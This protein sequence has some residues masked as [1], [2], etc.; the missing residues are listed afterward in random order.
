M[1]KSRSLA[2][3]FVLQF[4]FILLPLALVV[5]AQMVIDSWNAGAV[6]RSH[7]VQTDAYKLRGHFKGFLDGVV[8]AVDTGALSN[9]AKG[10]LG[11][12]RESMETLVSDE[13]GDETLRP[14]AREI[15]DLNSAVASASRLQDLVALR[16]A[17]NAADADI[18]ALV[19][20][21]DARVEKDLLSTVGYASA[22]R[23]IVPLVLI[24]TL[25]ITALFIRNTLTRP[26]VQ[27]EDAAN[28]IAAGRI[29]PE[30]KLDLR[31][32]LGS[33]L[34]SIAWMNDSL[35]KVI[36]RVKSAAQSVSGS[37]QE[38]ATNNGEIA[39]HVENEAAAIEQIAG[40]MEELAATVKQNADN[41]VSANGLAQG[42]SDAAASART[43]MAEVVENMDNIGASARQIAGIVALIDDIAFQT[44]ILAL[45]AAVEAA[46]AGE[47]GR[48]FAVVA[49][50]VRA[51]AMKSATSAKDIKRLVN[52][53]V[54]NVG[55]GHD[56][57]QGA[58]KTI[59]K[60][61]KSIQNVALLMSDIASAS[62]EQA[63]G[64]DEAKTA[65]E[66]MDRAI[67][68]SS[69]LVGN[70]VT[71]S[72]QLEAAALNLT[73]LVDT[74]SLD[75]AHASLGSARE[76]TTEVGQEEPPP[77]SLTSLKRIIRSAGRG[78]FNRS[79]V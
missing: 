78:L 76:D 24:V 75:E 6:E 4:A 27:A 36:H 63:G 59:E 60:A 79:E 28:T 8:D 61:V 15:G 7:K 31:N 65:V 38:L 48:G 67:S 13:P 2:S 62:R 17:I 9:S 5:I 77:N 73:D 30:L 68:S 11:L 33:L 52:S 39:R 69:A 14:L 57:V 51:L 55:Q 1:N 58:A 53:A 23:K 25:V 12:A 74:F 44:N 22:Q 3:R 32:D 37:A 49:S 54:S 56:L 21:Y 66:G 41:A 47:S 35:Y 46:R 10:Q 71:A 43:I 26:I 40:G 64:I 19:S 50:E 70:A 42:A 18:S 72:K 16:P 29:S 34:R 45:N 20:R